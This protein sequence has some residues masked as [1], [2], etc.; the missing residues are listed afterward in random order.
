MLEGGNRYYWG[1]EFAI[2][3]FE[4]IFQM[5]FILIDI[6]PNIN[7]STGII[8]IGDHVN[9]LNEQ[10]IIINKGLVTNRNNL[11]TTVEM[12]DYTKENVHNNDIELINNYKIYCLDTLQ[13]Y[14][15]SK[16]NRFAFI[17]YD[18]NN[19]HFESLYLET[20]LLPEK[21]IF[22]PVN[23]IPSYIKYMIFTS[24]YRFLKD[25][26]KSSPFAGIND[27]NKILISLMNMT[28]TKIENN[29]KVIVPSKKLQY[30]GATKQNTQI[31]NLA[32]RYTND[33]FNQYYDSTL[34]YYI[35]IDLELYPG[36]SIDNARGIALNCSNTYNKMWG[37]LADMVGQTYQPTELIVPSTFEKST[38]K[39]SAQN[40]RKTNKKQY[41][42]LDGSHNK[43]NVTRRK[44]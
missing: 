7:R 19:I 37:A 21:Y 9:I 22:T 36:D 38:F 32:S 17:L 30:G 33:S 29:T 2:R 23:D 35:V 14:D 6:N 28:N 8:R 43:H 5:K 11:I 44:K 16:I 15:M 10:G 24:C 20:R 40:Q 12:N 4:Y 1:D 25:P 27:L 13:F 41:G 39:K 26:Q 3:C 18:P 31:Q 42:G 34:G